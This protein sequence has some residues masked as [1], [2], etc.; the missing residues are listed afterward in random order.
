MKVVKYENSFYR[1]ISTKNGCLKLS[2]LNIETLEKSGKAELLERFSNEELMQMIIDR[3][4][5]RNN[6]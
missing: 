2:P 6:A 3:L 5:E 4:E 1:V